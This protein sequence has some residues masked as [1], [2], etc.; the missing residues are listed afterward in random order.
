MALGGLWLDVF[1]GLFALAA[2][3]E[4]VLLIRKATANLF[5]QLAGALGA[6]VY[7]GLATGALLA[8]PLFALIVTLA[9]VICTDVGAYFSGR[10]IGGPKI[11]PRISPSK[12]WAGLA[13]GMLAAAI[14]MAL[15]V[16]MIGLIKALYFAPLASIMSDIFPMETRVTGMSLSYSI[17][18]SV[19][20]GFA[21]A[22]SI[23]LI[24]ITGT[25]VATSYYLI[26]ASGL[27]ICALLVAA[28][29]LK[30]R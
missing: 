19:F 30:V 14:L 3:V 1:I 5:F 15:V 16:G 7:V 2:L 21:P 24:K 29:K 12:T 13:G 9:T 8:M 11:A 27:S 26:A 18:V 17:G 23:F 4:F 25:P 6:L 10:T 20:G 22:I 28:I